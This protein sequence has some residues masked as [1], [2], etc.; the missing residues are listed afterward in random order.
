MNKTSVANKTQ[1]EVNLQDFS[2]VRTNVILTPDQ[3]VG[4]LR[5]MMRIRRFEQAALKYYNQGCMG[6]FLHLYIGQQAV[7]VGAL[8]LLNVDDHI[9]TAYTTHDPAMP[10]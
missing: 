9:I 6:G 7:A 10:I 3:K 4:F 8:S 2:K 5:G 1:K